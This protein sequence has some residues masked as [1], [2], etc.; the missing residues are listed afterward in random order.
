METP[1]VELARQ[2]RFRERPPALDGGR[3]YAQRFRRLLD[4][5]AAEEPDLNDPGQIRIQHGETSQRLVQDFE[6][7]RLRRGCNQPGIEGDAHLI[8]ATL[9]GSA[10]P[11]A[12]DEN[13]SHGAGGDA[14]KVRP[15]LPRQMRV[16][17]QAEVDVMHERRGLERLAGT[18]TPEKAGGQ[19][20][21]L[22]VDQRHQ[23]R[24][25]LLIAL[26]SAVHER[27]HSSRGFIHVP[28]ARLLQREYG[29][30]E[31]RVSS[32]LSTIS[33]DIILWTLGSGPQ[34]SMNFEGDA[35]ISYAHLDNVELIEG[36]KGWVATL[37]RALQTRVAQLH[38][39]EARIWWDPKL[40]GNDYFADT[41]VERLQRVKALVA[42]V[43]PRYVKSEWGRREL[44]EFCKAA[45]QQGGVRVQDRARIFKVL[46]T[47]VERELHPPEL[48]SLLGYEFFKVDPDTGKVRE[49]ALDEIFGPEVQKDFCLKLDDL[50]H[51]ICALLNIL[52]APSLPAP[53]DP[54]PVAG[55][56]YVAVTTS[57]LKD[58]R[59]VI[60]RDLAQH[61]Y[62]V[63]PDRPLPLAAPE[64][65]A[66]VR[67]D[68][69]SCRMSIHMVGRTYSMV[70]EGGRESLV[71]LQN[72]LAIERAA[73]GQF[74]RLVWIPPGVHVDDERQRKVLDGLRMDP[75]IEQG[76]D[77]LETPLE[78]LRTDDRGAAQEGRQARARGC[79]FPA[80][81]P[82]ATT[83]GTPARSRRGPIFCSRISRSSTQ[84]LTA[85]RPRLAPTTRKTSR[86]A[87]ER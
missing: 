26:T 4:G 10:S 30:V 29:T 45:D 41:L 6:V 63:F 85:M 57:E 76:A 81:L 15:I 56:V 22:V 82:D 37:H 17:Q 70:P 55:G 87:T 65:Q 24:K 78:D 9:G 2:P 7:D 51:D 1:G 69:A 59:E 79:C 23:R 36:H 19:A 39:E 73:R 16:L 53:A 75:R 66:A 20:P 44:V 25:R 77:L 31:K 43:T 80:G 13:L 27:G 54:P 74:S 3:R 50:A 61:G 28:C 58:Q 32:K 48:Q 52:A 84:S 67:D 11:G 12:L 83:S 5:E 62:T 35:F 33:K 60:K 18:L 38:G 47:P 72:E 49:L 71:E 64:M 21:Q 34:I 14:E 42:V 68:L 8:A 40:H 86:V 46:K